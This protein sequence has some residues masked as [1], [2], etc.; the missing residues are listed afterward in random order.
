[1]IPAYHTPLSPD[2]QRALGIET[3]QPLALADRVRFSELDALN[4]VNNAVYME[5]FERLRIRYMQDWGLSG[6]DQ[7][8]D[9]RIVIRS[10]QIH[11]REE[12][13]MDEDYVATCGCTGWR[14]TSFSLLQ[15]VWS[16][17]TLR[18]TFECV[19][20]LLAPDGSGRF[21][22]PGPVRARF[23]SIDGAQP[24]GPPSER[25]SG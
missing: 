20:V 10:G 12:M 13:R 23:A 24:D 5:W 4:H 11:Y 16:G 9:P 1:M 25:N 8:D 15:Q 22:I 3:P 7:T 14:N 17:G 21:A 18:T 19:I 6:F 2:Q